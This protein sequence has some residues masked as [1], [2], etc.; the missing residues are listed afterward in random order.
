M[1]TIPLWS[2]WL[3]FIGVSIVV[4]IPIYF[5]DKFEELERWQSI[6]FAFLI[7]SIIMLFIFPL[8]RYN[9]GREWAFYLL[10][11]ITFLFSILFM[12]Y[13]FTVN[14]S[15]IPKFVITEEPPPES[16]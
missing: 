7:A 6:F 15:N 2:G 10:V 1:V 12:C 16:K 4:F 14:I 5:I 8:I 3:I 13:R 9:E 11:I